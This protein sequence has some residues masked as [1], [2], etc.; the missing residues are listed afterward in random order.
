MTG[1]ARVGA[2]AGALAG[3]MSGLV[4]GIIMVLLASAAGQLPFPKIRSQMIPRT[5]TQIVCHTN[6]R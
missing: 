3:L 2:G 5:V 4:L 6:K 1:G